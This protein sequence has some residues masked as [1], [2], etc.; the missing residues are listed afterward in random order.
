M[1]QK[2]TK[3]SLSRRSLLLGGLALPLTGCEAPYGIDMKTL[4]QSAAISLGIEEPP[5]ITLE[6]ASKIP[7]A[8]ISLQIGSEA[9]RVIVLATEGPS[10]QIWTSSERQAI[11]TKAGRIIETA[12][13][14]WNLTKMDF[15]NGDPLPVLLQAAGPKTAVPRY[16]DF[17]DINRYRVTVCGRFIKTGF[18]KVTMLGTELRLLK[19]MERCK[20]DDINWE[21]S[22]AF[23]ID[24]NSGFVWRSVQTIHPNLPAITLNILR[25]PG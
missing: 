8:S 3:H 17:Q 14:A 12:G 21:F 24:P 25:P 16:V 19:F 5:A 1:K 2:P 11:V 23:W 10:G 9:P 13:L 18:E 22:N 7:Y 4:R 6:Q 20:S 15:P